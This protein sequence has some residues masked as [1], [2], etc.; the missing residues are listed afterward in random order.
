[1]VNENSKTNTGTGC[2]RA[3]ADDVLKSFIE[4]KKEEIEKLQTFLDSF[5]WDALTPKQELHM[6]QLVSDLIHA[7]SQRN[8][9]Y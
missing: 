4:H 9:H 8:Q 2:G 3:R 1:M 5:D 6:F 7:N